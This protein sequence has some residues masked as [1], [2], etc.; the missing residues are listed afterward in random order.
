MTICC[1]VWM[2]CCGKSPVIARRGSPGGRHNAA[3]SSMPLL[4][5]DSRTFLAAQGWYG[6]GSLTTCCDPRLAGAARSR[7]VP[8]TPS[9]ELASS[10]VPRRLL[11]PCQTPVKL[12]FPSEVRGTVR[13]A[14][15]LVAPL[16][17]AGAAGVCA[18]RGAGRQ[19]TARI[20]G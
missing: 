13:F 20:I 16:A 8:P 19:A 18:D 14:E 2:I 4:L 5:N 1:G 3:G 10:Q 15:V 17:G 9:P 12:G 6:A 11:P 7:P